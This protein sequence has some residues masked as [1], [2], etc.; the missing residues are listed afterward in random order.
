MTVRAVRNNN[1]G[2]IE[3]G[4]TVWRGE[5]VDPA[6]MTPEQ[7]KETRFAVFEHPIWGF[8]AI[9]RT[10]RTYASH[11]IN[12]VAKIIGRWAP[13]GEN[14]TTAYVRHVCDA[15][16]AEPEQMLDMNDHAV[17]GAIARAIAVHESGGWFFETADL[18]EGV[19]LAFA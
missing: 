2:N 3:R 16:G 11:R 13:A 8:R 5:I 1:P 19:K 17:I 4:R 12:S 18:D 14:D 7:R 15:V 10:L 6:R 9:A